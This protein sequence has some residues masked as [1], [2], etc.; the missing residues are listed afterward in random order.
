MK[1]YEISIDNNVLGNAKIYFDNIK[2]DLKSSLIESNGGLT[3][4]NVDEDS[5]TYEITFIVD[6]VDDLYDVVSKFISDSDQVFKYI[7]EIKEY[8]DIKYIKKDTNIR[9]VVSEKNLNKLDISK[10]NIDYNSLLKSKIHFIKSVIP[11]LNSNEIVSSLNNIINEYNNYINSSEYEFL[12]D[13]EKRDKINEFLNGLNKLIEFIENNTKYKYGKNY[14]VP[15]K[16]R[17]D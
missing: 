1:E 11:K 17:R 8:N 14:V 13:D 10:N 15:I 2:D 9:V 5:Q 6:S 16:I 12:T 7:E 3:F 4:L